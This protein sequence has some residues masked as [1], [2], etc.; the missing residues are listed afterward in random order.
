MATL[1]I[2]GLFVCLVQCEWT[3]DTVVFGSECDVMYDGAE[4]T[5]KLTISGSVARSLRRAGPSAVKNVV[6]GTAT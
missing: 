1:F 4:E 5:K 6:V 2:F 3:R